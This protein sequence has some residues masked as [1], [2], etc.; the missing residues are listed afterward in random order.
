VVVAV[1]DGRGDGVDGGGLPEDRNAK[2]QH[3]QNAGA[4]A[5]AWV[6]PATYPRK[7][8]AEFLCCQFNRF[9]Y[10]NSKSVPPVALR[11]ATA[12]LSISPDRIPSPL[13]WR[14]QEAAAVEISTTSGLVR[15]AVRP[16]THWFF[17]LAQ[18]AILLLFTKLLIGRWVGMPLLWRGLAAWAVVATMV[19]WFYQLSG[20]EVIEF[21]PQKLS[22]CKDNLG[23]ERRSEHLIEACTELQWHEP[24][25]SDNGGLQC[26]IGWRSVRFGEYI[27]EDQANEI[28][29]ALQRTLP[30]VAQKM[31]AMP[32]Q[33]KSPFITLGLG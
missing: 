25:D 32:S 5:L 22:V 13:N 18:A 21:G 31:G 17:M 2:C 28:L 20:S 11:E 16:R 26:K 1:V 19:A 23:W 33:G 15:V 24:G 10:F 29:A 4:G 14:K 3:D 9:P 27:S 6:G 7:R 30:D 12:S 8:D